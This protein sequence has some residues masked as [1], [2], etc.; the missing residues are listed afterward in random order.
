MIT[1]RNIMIAV[2]S[3]M[4]RKSM[5]K[6]KNILLVGVVL[7]S[8][9]LGCCVMFVSCD[10]EDLTPS[11]GLNFE[12]VDTDGFYGYCVY[13]IGSCKD[14]HVVVPS[15]HENLPVVAVLE[16]VSAEIESIYL[17]ESVQFINED[18]FA[19]NVSMK[20]ITM[21]GV[22]HIDSNAFAGC[23]SLKEVTIPATT[24]NIVHNAF[25]GCTSLKKVVFENTSGWTYRTS[26][27][28]VSANVTDPT[29]NVNRLSVYMETWDAWGEYTNKALMDQWYEAHPDA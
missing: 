27:G 5:K 8:L 22:T 21:A 1:A 2:K 28:T 13:D 24:F 18:A 14:T 19:G 11:K 15:V 26:S 4:R 29:V 12:F 23:T 25:Y 7:L 10:S 17:P 20:K 6:T 16:L 9:V 3:S